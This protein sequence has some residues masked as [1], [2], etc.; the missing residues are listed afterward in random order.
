M[1]LSHEE[2]VVVSGASTGLGAATTQE[3]ARRGYHVLAG[4][5]GEQA[6][7]SIRSERVEPVIL[8][9][10]DSAH[11]AA[12][13]R[14][15]A[16]DPR[17][18]RALI[19]NAGMAANAPVEALPLEVW[20]RMFEVNLFGHIAMTQGLLPALRISGGRVVNVSSTGGKI[21]M[22]AFGAYSATKYAVE[23]MS[24]SLRR[25]LAGQGVDVVIVE[26]GAVKTDMVSTGTRAAHELLDAMSD[27]HRALYADTMAAFLVQTAE[28]GRSG[29]PAAEA[30]R[31][32]ARAVTARRPRTRYTIGRDAAVFTALSRLLPD[33]V[34]DRALASNQRRALRNAD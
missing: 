21:A 19:N 11:V 26:P 4:V 16:V 12:V 10:T 25:E 32:M 9:I 6:A 24:D 2:I 7:E 23:A 31:T 14:R 8:D 29:L 28:F 5:R 27:E 13:A 33:R 3:L 18:L 30:A 34:L 17:P 1:T 22:P 20:R 15:V